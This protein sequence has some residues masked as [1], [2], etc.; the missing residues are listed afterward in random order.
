MHQ[1]S[2]VLS[3]HLD[4]LPLLKSGGRLVYRKALGNNNHNL[5]PYF[6]S[7]GSPTCPHDVK[8]AEYMVNAIGAGN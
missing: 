4:E 3:K 7:N 6:D 1:P 8:P 2:I 5:I